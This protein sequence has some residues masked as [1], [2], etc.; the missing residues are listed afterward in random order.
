MTISEDDLFKDPPPKEDCPICF[1][2]IPHS[3]IEMSVETVY[4]ACCGKVLCSGCVAAAQN[5]INRGNMKSCCPFCRECL[6][7]SDKCA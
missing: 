4:Q 2:P 3:P 7:V 1:L 5:E 6:F